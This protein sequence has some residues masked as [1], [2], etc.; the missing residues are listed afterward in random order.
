VAK[1]CKPSKKITLTLVVVA[2]KTRG[3]HF[4]V[5]VMFFGSIKSSWRKAN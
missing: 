5:Q 3:L 4:L 2:L 1:L